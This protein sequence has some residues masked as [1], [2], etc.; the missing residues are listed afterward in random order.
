[1][2]TL[3]ELNAETVA[4]TNLLG[5][6]AA[7]LASF[8][9]S[10]GEPTYRAAQVLQWIHQRGVLDFDAMNNLSK[11]LRN[12]LKTLA[13]ITLPTVVH[14]S[15]AACGTRKWLMQVTG[16][17]AI[18][19]VLIPEPNRA[20]LCISSQVGCLLDCAFCSTGKQGFHRHLT[21]AEIIGQLWYA[22]HQLLSEGKAGVT[23]VVMMGM[24]EPLLNRDQ[25]FPALHIMRDDKAY[26][27]SKRRVTVST[28]GVVPGIEALT[29]ECD[30]ALA[31]S[32]H[33]PNDNLRDELVPINKKYPL[34][35]L[36]AACRGYLDAD[37][38]RHITV[39]YVMLA[40]VN[41]TPMHA[42]QLKRLLQGYACKVN[43]IPFNP[44]P[45]VEFKR[46]S[47]EAIAAFKTILIKA[48]IIT[49][50]RKTRGDDIDAACGQLAG[51]VNDKTFRQ[52]RWLA[53]VT[54]TTHAPDTLISA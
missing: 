46:S 53:K 43:L 49:T 4:K 7:G 26:G 42:N 37:P 25:V 11:D 36:M 2:S 6:S 35:M 8:M 44:F 24:G 30:V 15:E 9:T 18:E 38:R 48:D 12:R 29:K 54:P 47:P 22:H 20:T 32:L 40:G 5:L 21:S 34:A 3:T 13:E 52:S 27:L 14:T 31:I 33:A 19:V 50:V 10:I 51:Q 1:M 23:N 39:E 28:A 17:S 45:H 41:D 16:G